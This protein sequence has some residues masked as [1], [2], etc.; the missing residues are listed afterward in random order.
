MMVLKNPR[1][2]PR[3]HLVE[4]AL[5]EAVQEGRLEKTRQLIS[6]LSNPFT[7]QP[8]IERYA[9]APTVDDQNYQTFCGT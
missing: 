6:V 7:D 8:L 1:Y 9:A 3:N 5:S 2:I 4:E